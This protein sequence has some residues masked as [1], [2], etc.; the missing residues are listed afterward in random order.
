MI[1][2][3]ESLPSDPLAALMYSLNKN[4][5]SIKFAASTG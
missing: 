1:V 5:N 2:T 4:W 3:A